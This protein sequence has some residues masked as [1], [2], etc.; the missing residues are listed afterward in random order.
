MKYDNIDLFAGKPENYRW[1]TDKNAELL[2]II[3]LGGTFGNFLK[4]FLEKFSTKTPDMI[5]DPF[6]ETGTS[7][8]VKD[9]NFSGLIQRYHSS[10]INDNRGEDNLPVCIISPSTRKHYLF[11]KKSQWYRG[12]DRKNSPD[13]LWKL[14]V[15]EMPTE[16]Q[17]LAKEIIKLYDIK[18]VAHYFWIPKFIIRD[19]YKLEFLK[20]LEDTYNH[21]NVQALKQHEF[22]KKQKTCH[23]DLEAFFDWETFIESITELDDMF[24]LALDYRRRAEMRELFDKGIQLD[25]IRQECNLVEAVLDKGDDQPLNGLDVATEGFIYAETE[26]KNDFIQ[27]PLTN[28]FFRDTDEMMQFIEYYPKHYKAMNPNMPKFNGIP[29]PFYLDKLK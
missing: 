8:K 23:L 6:T 15:G 27:M 16:M 13:D 2:N 17:L 28:R 21:R 4:F 11:L 18:E 3:F 20:P 26:R 10:F 19:W 22:F 25:I 1:D 24:G 29:N 7:H 5:G 14:A 12:S 9:S